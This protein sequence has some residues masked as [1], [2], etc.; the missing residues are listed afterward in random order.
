MSE[1]T[2]ASPLLWVV[3]LLIILALLAIDLGI[4]QRNGREQ[5]MREAIWFCL[6]WVSLAAAF[7]IGV[8]Y[9]LGTEHALEFLAGYLVEQSLSVDNIFLFILIFSHYKVP[10]VHRRRLLFYGVLGAIVMRGIFIWAGAELLATFHFIIYGFGALLLLT[11]WRM[12]ASGDEEREIEESRVIKLARRLIPGTTRYRD[13]HFFVRENGRLLATPLFFVLI[14]IEAS[15]LVFAVDSI[16][17]VFAITS[18]PFIVFTSNIFAIL[19]LRSLF[20]VLS[21]GLAKLCYL[22]YG[23]AAILAFV[24]TKMILSDVFE[25]P[26]FPSLIVIALTLA[27]TIGLSLAREKRALRSATR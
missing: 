20:F 24:G 12:L 22:R 11:A 17:A 8:Y 2:S 14:V 19:G 26:T 13:H 25:I 9:C 1:L 27:A 21:K 10:A 3:S 4:L 5:T 7:N 15:D 23:L 18:D 16:P 6:G